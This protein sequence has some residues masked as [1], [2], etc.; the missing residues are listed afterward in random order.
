M[1]MKDQEEILKTEWN[2]YQLEKEKNKMVK[3]LEEE[4]ESK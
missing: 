1:K 4:G 3:K 2:K